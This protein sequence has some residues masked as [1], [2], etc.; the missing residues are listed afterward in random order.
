M[1]IHHC[2]RHQDMQQQTRRFHSGMPIRHAFRYQGP[3]K[4]T[5]SPRVLFHCVAMLDRSNN[6]HK[7]L[8]HTFFA[9]PLEQRWNSG[10][11][12]WRTG[13]NRWRQPPTCHARL[14][15]GDKLCVERDTPLPR[16]R[17]ACTTTVVCT[18]CACSQRRYVFKR[19]DPWRA[20]SLLTQGPQFSR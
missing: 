5:E 17:P 19:R 20:T 9:R 11:D 2:A 12:A 1:K 4:K 8:L 6:P 3:N 18:V 7:D 14:R 13:S 10:I 16:P 15:H